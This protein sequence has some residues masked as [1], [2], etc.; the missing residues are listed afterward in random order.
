[1]PVF[2]EAGN[3][4]LV[5]IGWVAAVVRLLVVQGGFI[6]NWKKR[7]F[8]LTGEHLSYYEGA[9]TEPP[10]GEILM[11][12]INGV[13]VRMCFIVFAHAARLSIAEWALAVGVGVGSWRMQATPPASEFFLF[14]LHLW[15]CLLGSLE[16]L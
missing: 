6:H 10:K 7:L 4:S 1:V 13:G 8:V 16:H 2:A 5:A 3:C 11:R 9:S 14:C 15:D 12:Q